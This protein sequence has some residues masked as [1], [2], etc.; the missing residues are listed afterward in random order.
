MR[1]LG[2]LAIAVATY[3]PLRARAAPGALLVSESANGSVIDIAAGGDLSAAP[4]FATGLSAPRGLC[5]GPGG[6]VYVAESAGAQVTVITDGG[7]F[8]DA[9][10]FAYVSAGGFFPVSLACDDESIFMLDFQGLLLD[11]SAG[12]DILVDPMLF[13]FGHG[14]SI[15]LLR[16]GTDVFV[17]AGDVFDVTAGGDFTGIPGYATGGGVGAV[18]AWDGMRLGAS[19]LTPVIYDWTA[20]GALGEGTVWARLPSNVAGDNH[21]DGLLVAGDR[22]LALSDNAVY[23]VSTG[24]DLSM[25]MPF[26]TGLLGDRVGYEGMIRHVCSVDADCDDADACNGAEA[27]DDNACVRAAAVVCDDDDVCT[28]DS[29]DPGDGCRNESIAG[30]CTEDADCALFEICDVANSTCVE[31]AVGETSGGADGTTGPGADGGDDG[32]IGSTGDDSSSSDD[33]STTPVSVSAGGGSSESSGA[34]PLSGDASGCACAM[35]DAATL[36]RW[37]WL[38]LL[39]LLARRGRRHGASADGARVRDEFPRAH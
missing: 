33:G 21:V 24:G 3:L 39:P 26:A 10:P 1:R 15:G 13:S 17:A 19:F 27:C 7:D 14:S 9:E 2:L 4:R 25:A 32:G 38:G 18:A 20:G 5:I 16:D 30:C 23:D 8:S 37:S 6:D 11:I 28:A 12:G 29:C 36:G 22:L 31:I 34:A 35:D